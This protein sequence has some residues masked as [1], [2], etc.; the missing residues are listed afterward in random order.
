MK[1]DEEH[2]ETIEITWHVSHDDFTTEDE[3]DWQELVQNILDKN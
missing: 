3:D 2:P 1:V